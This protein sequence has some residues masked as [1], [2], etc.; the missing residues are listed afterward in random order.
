M[1]LTGFDFVLTQVR[2]YD[3]YFMEFY[4]IRFFDTNATKDSEKGK[5]TCLGS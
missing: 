4:K 3:P 5:W 2:A 1:L